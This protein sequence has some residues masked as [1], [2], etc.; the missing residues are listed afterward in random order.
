[1]RI[2][3]I[4]PKFWR[5]DDIDSLDWHTRLVFIGLWS[6]VDDNGVGLDK[7]SAITADLFAHDFSVDPTE[8]LRRV[9]LALDELSLRG[10]LTRYSAVGKRFLFVNNWDQYQKPKNPAQPR[11]TRPTC[12]NDG[13]TESLRTSSVDPTESLPTGEGEKGRRGEGEKSSSNAGIRARETSLPALE[14]PPDYDDIPE[15]ITAPKRPTPDRATAAE[16]TRVRTAI[17][18]GH[19]K[20]IEQQLAIQVRKLANRYDHDVIDDAL[21]RWATKTGIGPGVLPGLVS[22]VIKERHAP[23]R[24]SKTDIWEANV[25]APAQAAADQQHRELA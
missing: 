3:S 5:S 8:T 16:L 23:R 15:E 18:T 9:S 7:L 2:R 10:M 20:D 13:S 25:V 19:P 11:Y 24:Q 21:Q 12:I 6:Y 17:G 22:D 1:M 4:V 14:V